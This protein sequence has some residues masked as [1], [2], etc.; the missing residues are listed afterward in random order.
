[1]RYLI[2]NKA[3]GARIVRT[4]D[5]GAKQLRPGQQLTAE[6]DA[7][8]LDWLE[9]AGLDLTPVDDE[10]PA[11]TDPLN[12][13][14]VG[15]MGGSID[16]LDQMK[17]PALKELANRDGVDLMGATKRADIIEAIRLHREAKA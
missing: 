12:A 8:H 16:E 6:V 2:V 15:G 5:K 17:A 7:A 10:A 4:L 1:M 11:V 9:G 14:G 13:D 3:K